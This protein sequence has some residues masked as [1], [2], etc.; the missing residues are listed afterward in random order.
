VESALG[1][2]GTGTTLLADTT[3]AAV[4]ELSFFLPLGVPEPTLAYDCWG[5]GQS[6]ARCPA[7]K[8]VG[9]GYFPSRK[10]LASQESGNLTAYARGS[11]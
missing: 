9:S 5:L 1:G 10:A 4:R 2:S 6:G 3:L 8:E 7:T 11:P